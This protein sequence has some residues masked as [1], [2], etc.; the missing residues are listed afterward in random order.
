[1]GEIS[2]NNATNKKQNIRIYALV[3]HKN[4][5]TLSTDNIHEDFWLELHETIGW[6]KFVKHSEESEF[7]KNGAL[8]V[9]T[10]LR[11]VSDSTPYPI[12]EA[13]CVLWR[14]R[15]AL[16]SAANTLSFLLGQERLK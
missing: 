2:V 10:E 11:P 4:A 3:F 13:R 12:V 16:L 7:V 8:F 6:I 15:E 9:A 14:Q 5:L 1:M